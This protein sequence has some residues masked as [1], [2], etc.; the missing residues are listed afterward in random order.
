MQRILA[1]QIKRIGDLVL[2]APAL[3]RLRRA[4]PDAHITLLTL[5]VAG[6]LVPCIPWIDEHLNYRPGRPNLALWAQLALGR[7]DV[8]LDFNGNDRAAFMTFLSH[9]GIRA[10]YEKRARKFPRSLVFNRVSDASLTE[11]HTVDHM[12]ALL[13]TLGI[14]SPEAEPLELVVPQA[15]SARIRALLAERGIG[16]GQKFALIHPGTARD[17][18][19]W[20]AERWATVADYLATQRGLKIVLTGGKDAGEKAHIEALTDAATTQIVDLSGE[21]SLLGS[22]AVISLASLA[23]GVDTAAMHLAGAFEIPQVMLYGP[24][25]P[26]HWRPRHAAARVVLA[27]SD[28]PLTKAEDFEMRISKTAMSLIEVDQVLAA[29]DSLPFVNDCR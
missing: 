20:L 9:A 29:V 7:Y 28:A 11:L 14:D 24:T 21:L 10:G 8:V 22:A 2:T 5:G 27:G 18:K 12:V 17:E 3:R 25:N 6:Q 23:L 16:E 15:E 26:Y 19:Y 1:I 13:A 4:R